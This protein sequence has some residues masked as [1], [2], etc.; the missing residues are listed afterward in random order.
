MI[1]QKIK[2]NTGFTLV[3]TMFAVFILTST[4]VG[5][6]TVVSNSLFAA[7]YARDEI[8]V[9]YL[10]QEVVDYIRNDRDTTVFL[11]SVGTWESFFAKYNV[12][13]SSQVGGCYFDVLSVINPKSCDSFGPSCPYLYYDGNAGATENDATTFY[14]TDDGINQNK[15]KTNFRRK[16]VVEQNANLDEI[17]VT[18]TVDWLNGGLPM[19]RSLKTSFLKWQ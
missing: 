2:K 4:I 7:R 9:N 6:M 3:E 1:N 8:T 13:C 19:T 17:D 16:I 11:G 5:L 12:S 10:L 18:V 15:T 14:V